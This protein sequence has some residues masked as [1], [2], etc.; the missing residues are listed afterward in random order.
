[1]CPEQAMASIAAQRQAMYAVRSG[2]FNSVD[3][4]DFI[5]CV[6][7][8]TPRQGLKCMHRLLFSQGRCEHLSF[9]ARNVFADRRCHCVLFYIVKLGKVAMNGHFLT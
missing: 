2:G 6:A 5:W 1:M 7:L 9:Y 4:Q 3:W 8:C